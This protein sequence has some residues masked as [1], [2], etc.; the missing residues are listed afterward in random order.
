M[1]VSSIGALGSPLPVS[2]VLT[3]FAIMIIGEWIVT[4]S[5]AA[6]CS[7][8]WV[9]RYTTNIPQ[10]WQR[11]RRKKRQV[12]WLVAVGVLVS[13]LVIIIIPDEQCYTS[14]SQGDEWVL[15]QCPE[16][17]ESIANMQKVGDEFL[18]HNI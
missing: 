17:P 4:D 5:I 3:N 10:A 9:S 11:I 14:A 13:M 18:I 1:T 8:H 15:G 12:A 6:Y 7:H 16:P 2:R